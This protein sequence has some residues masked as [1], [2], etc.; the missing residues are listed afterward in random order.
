MYL[1][2]STVSLQFGQ[3]VSRHNH[4]LIHAEWNRWPHGFVFMCSSITS[5]SSWQIVHVAT[6]T[7]A[8]R[9]RLRLSSFSSLRSCLRTGWWWPQYAKGKGRSTSYSGIF[10]VHMKVHWLWELLLKPMHRLETDTKTASSCSF[11]IDTA[12]TFVLTVVSRIA[13]SCCCW[14]SI[15]YCV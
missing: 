9:S 15:V 5:I 14:V 2:V 6:C 10:N 11:S 4:L 13:L 12:F 3:V 7:R 8:S 1:T